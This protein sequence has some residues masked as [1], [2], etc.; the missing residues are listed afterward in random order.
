MLASDELSKALIEKAGYFEY[1][2]GYFAKEPEHRFKGEEYYFSLQGDYIGFGS[3]AGSIL[4]HH[5]LLNVSGNLHKFMA[6]PLEFDECE[7]FSPHD[8]AVW[9]YLRQALLT[10]TGIDFH[11][12]KRLFGFD[13][14]EI[15]NRPSFEEGLD[16]FRRC[17]AV[18][19]ET[20]EYLALTD[21][22]RHKA[23]IMSYAMSLVY[24]P[25]IDSG[26]RKKVPIE[27]VSAN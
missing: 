20:E 4:G 6:H 27:T 2:L 19:E 16:F 1:V 17:G 9:R 10:S 21:E 15:R 23:Y 22:T 12:F 11:N 8:S 3:G 13:F 5:S 7:K 24:G 18:F 26:H 25:S 14:A